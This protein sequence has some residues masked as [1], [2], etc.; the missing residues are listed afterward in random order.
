LRAGFR[1]GL[2]K[3]AGA[4]NGPKGFFEKQHPQWALPEM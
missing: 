2:R 4:M 1:R 3:C